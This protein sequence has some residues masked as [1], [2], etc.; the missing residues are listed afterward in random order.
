MVD[1]ILDSRFSRGRLQYKVN[2]SGY[3]LDLEWYNTDRNEF[4]HAADVI[5]EYY[6]QYPNKPGPYNRP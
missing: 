2:W 4:E 5:T 1:N 6:R 3:D